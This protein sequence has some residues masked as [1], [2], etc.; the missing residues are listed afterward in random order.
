RTARPDVS[1]SRH[2]AR[3]RESADAPP[4]AQSIL[5]AANAS[6]AGATK[7]CATEQLN[8]RLY[9]ADIRNPSHAR[10]SEWTPLSAPKIVRPNS[11]LYSTGSPSVDL[12][13]YRRGRLR[14][15]DGR[16]GSFGVATEA[17]RADSDYRSVRHILHRATPAL[18]G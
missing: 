10:D 18:R 8:F 9:H 2:H 17:A 11:R 16:A 1:R 15:G 7:T 3:P 6:Q 13:R 14:P 5:R 12:V 4:A